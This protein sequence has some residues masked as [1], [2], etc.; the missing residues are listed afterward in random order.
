MKKLLLLLLFVGLHAGYSDK[1]NT[2]KDSYNFLSLGIGAAT[3]DLNFSQY[4][5]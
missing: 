1:L 4:G 2:P 3:K 5:Q